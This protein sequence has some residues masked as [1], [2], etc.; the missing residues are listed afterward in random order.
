M[1]VRSILWAAALLLAAACSSA[2]APAATITSSV[3]AQPLTQV[4]SKADGSVSVKY[5]AGWTAEEQLGQVF[6]TTDRAVFESTSDSSNVP[7]GSL[8]MSIIA[9]PADQLAG[10][11]GV[12]VRAAPAAI[13][14]A[15]A[16]SELPSGVSM[17]EPS[18]L[19]VGSRDAARVAGTSTGTDALFLL[20][21][22]RDTLFSLV[23]V[24]TKNGEMALFEPTVL[25]I[26]ESVLYK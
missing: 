8:L 12:D 25:A 1:T 26:A 15:I 22:E 18:A 9:I 6:I 17:S 4:F 21:K 3:G 14:K 10:L 24:A 7:P 5:P 23:T 20:V 16:S 13:L 19:K 2:N 11:P